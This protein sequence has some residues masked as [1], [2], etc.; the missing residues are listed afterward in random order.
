MGPVFSL[1]LM[2]LLVTA[3]YKASRLK[4][5]VRDFETG[6]LYREGE[7]ERRLPAGAYRFPRWL[8]QA[9]V[10]DLRRR[11]QTISGHEILT[12]DKAGL[13]V[14]LAV[15]YELEDPIKAYHAVQ[16]YAEAVQ[17]QIQL[18]L[19]GAIEKRALKQ[20]LEQ[21]PAVGKEILTHVAPEA[22]KFGVKVLDIEVKD[23]TF[24]PDLNKILAEVFGSP[25]RS[26]SGAKRSR[27]AKKPAAV[28]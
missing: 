7:F 12:R 11:E 22:R 10:M 1:I 13:K 2:V 26:A 18:A 17:V 3:I 27:P 19:R 6:L 5:V 28:K 20:V 16:S 24:P 25:K 9:T 8:F 14:S 15:S 23:I 4:V 21:R